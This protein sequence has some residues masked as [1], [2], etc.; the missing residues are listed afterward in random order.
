MYKFVSTHTNTVD[1]ISTVSLVTD[2]GEASRN[3]GACGIRVTVV[4]DF[5]TLINILK[6][7]HKKNSGNYYDD[8]VLFL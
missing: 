3:V 1:S 7:A 2:T 5:L 6:I 8:K 4:S